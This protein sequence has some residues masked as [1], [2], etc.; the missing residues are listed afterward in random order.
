[1]LPP[2][3]P[4]MSSANTLGSD[5]D[6]ALLNRLCFFFI[7]AVKHFMPT[8]ASFENVEGILYKKN[9]DI[10]KRIIKNLL[11]LNYQVRVSLLNSCH[12]G[13][14]Q[15]RKRVFIFVAKKTSKLPEI[16]SA[17]YGEGLGQTP[18]LVVQDVVSDLE[19]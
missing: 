15:T 6:K 2:P 13:D 7:D 3:C 18:C 8:T 19:K 5:E 16:P 14:P 17:M 1:M 12:Y 10:L 9:R 11:E 4:G